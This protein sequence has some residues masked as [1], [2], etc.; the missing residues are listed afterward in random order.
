MAFRKKIRLG[1]LLAQDGL[2]NQEQLDRALAEQK[3]RGRKLGN[4][5]IDLGYVTE[6]QVL[7]SLA[8][9]LHLERVD[10]TRY[11]FD[12]EVVRMLPETQARRFRSVVL[13]D[14]GDALLVGMA[15]P[16]DIFAFDEIS[17]HLKRPVRQAVVSETQ[18]VRMLDRI[19]R[20]TAEISHLAEELGQELSESDYDIERL[21]EEDEQTEVPVAKL[22]KSL[23]ED[24][25]QV[26]ASD[27]HIEPDERVLR[28]RQRVDGVLQ[29]QEMKER[30]IAP[31]LVLRLK[32]MAGLDISEKR[33]P[34]DG[35]FNIRVKKRSI[36][37]RLSTMPVQYG[38]SV[39]MRLLDQSGE[40]LDLGQLGMNEDTV[41]RLRRN[42][43]HPYGM[44]L[45]TGP[46]GS[47]KTTTLY[48][49]LSELNNAEKKI[50]TAEDPVEYRMSRVNQ[51]Q[52]QPRIGLDFARILRS[53][54]RQDPDVMLV[55][56]MRDAETADIGLRAALT[57]HMVLSTLH[58]NDAIGTVDRLIDMGAEGYL[59]A[60]TLR[61]I[62]GQRLLRRVC[63]SCRRPTELDDTQRAWLES[64]IGEKRAAKLTF[65]VGKGCAQCNRTGYQGRIGV[66]EIL[67]LTSEMR[68]ALR[69]KDTVAFAAAA[70]K[71]PGYKPLV[72]SALELAARGTT[73]VR[74]VERIAGEVEELLAEH[75]MPGADRAEEDTAAEGVTSNAAL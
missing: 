57:G 49:A 23:F 35:R 58:T 69:R 17:R 6:D 73:T 55:G 59:I 51:V 29:E 31:A 10:L 67:E 53:A 45:V 42:I 56:E 18:L 8:R 3:R 52:I 37:V 21:L 32:L 62:V 11:D 65:Q 74:E 39:V 5:L 9:Q 26:G 4:T 72:A 47:G 20:R 15:D 16:T 25:V 60:A 28:I 34:Q 41:A 1:D 64:L 50:I 43:H 40:M 54:L 22:L 24:A 33:V 38:E 48:A 14:E 61:A 19:Y 7:D 44:V 68:T 66:Y 70:R 13:A 46:T 2:I 30:R 27:I 36:D 12:P 71:A 75:N 63:T